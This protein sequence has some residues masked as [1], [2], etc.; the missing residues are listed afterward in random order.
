MYD[1]GG[2]AADNV[3]VRAAAMGKS[4]SDVVVR[5]L[6][7]F[8]FAGVRGFCV[9]VEVEFYVDDGFEDDEDNE[10]SDWGLEGD[11]DEGAE[12]DGD[13]HDED[14]RIGGG[15]ELSGV[16]RFVFSPEE[17]VLDEGDAVTCEEDQQD[18]FRTR[19]QS[20][21]RLS[22]D[23]KEQLEEDKEAGPG[24]GAA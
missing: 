7:A 21:P 4:A 16:G 8:R 17:E 1:R 9:G 6:R 3:D 23:S 2:G 20:G 11:G 14:P 12:D 10:D 13:V 5:L 15:H 24:W 19:R 18:G 22:D